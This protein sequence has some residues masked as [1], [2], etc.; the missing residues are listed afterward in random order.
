MQQAMTGVYCASE[1][2]FSAAR[3]REI[4]SLQIVQNWLACLLSDPSKDTILSD[5][6]I[7]GLLC[8]IEL[9]Q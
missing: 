1:S 8:L 9:S 2:H 5:S 3:G 7:G 6:K 4:L